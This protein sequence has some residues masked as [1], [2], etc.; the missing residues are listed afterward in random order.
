MRKLFEKNGCKCEVAENGE[1]AL[2]KLKSAE[3]EHSIDMVFTDYMMPKM[4]GL[5]ESKQIR[6]NNKR[7][8][9]I[10]NTSNRITHDFKRKC[11]KKNRIQKV[12][13]KPFSKKQ[14]SPVFEKFNF[15]SI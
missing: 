4:N 1:E 13:S 8:P 12:F 5:E 9:I 10:L 15:P 6:K 14:L 7:V 2:E 3:E 11:K